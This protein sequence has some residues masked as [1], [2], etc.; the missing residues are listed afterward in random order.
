[1]KIFSQGLLNRLNIIQ[2]LQEELIIKFGQEDY[3]IF[4]FGSFLTER[5]ETGNSDVDF[6]VYTKNTSKYI[7]IADCVLDFF[8]VY[9]I[10]VDIFYIDINYPAPVYCAPLSSKI[11]FTN[12][13]PKKL[14][15]FYEQCKEQYEDCL[16]EVM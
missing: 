3:N 6:A 12:Y 10:E 1:M 16:N 13:Y 4:L 15:K 11:Q 2:K 8:K 9:K 7:E 14:K 5:F